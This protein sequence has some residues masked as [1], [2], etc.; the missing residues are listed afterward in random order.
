MII[1]RDIELRRG[2]KLLLQDAQ[3][4]IQPGQN[5]A[6]IG[7]NGSG[8]SSLFALLLGELGADT[9]EI[10]G[11]NN[12]RLSHMAQEVH[13][14]A[15]PA[16]EY[17][18]RGDE[19][20][21]RLMDRLAA[22]EEQGDY[23]LTAPIHTEL[24]S[25]DGYSAARKAEV[26]LQGLGFGE[27]AANRPVSDF[28]GGWR[29]RLN[30]ARALMTPSDMLLLDEPTNHLDLDATLWLQQWLQQYPG[31]LLMIS[32]DRDFI[33]GT[34]E[35]I[36]HIERQQLGS[37][38]GN[39]SQ[40][41]AQ[42]AERLANQQATFEKQQRRISEIDDFVRRFRYKATKAKQAQSR[43]KELE[44]MQTVAPAHID[45]PFDFSFLPPEK[46]SDPLL[47]LDKAALGYADQAILNGVDMQLRPG[48]RYGLL[49]R[50]GAGK[51]T[52]LKSLVGQ[53]PLVG[54][55]ISAGEHC[56]IGYFDQ[57]QLEALDM[58]ASPLLH[59][60]RLSPEAR[61]QEV[62]NFLG[63]FDFRGDA[64]S[65]PVAPFS[66]GEKARLALA[67]VVWQK[68]NLLVLDEPTNHLDLEMRHAMEVALQAFEGALILVSHDRHMLRNTVE[69]LLLVHDGQ[70]EEYKQDL[71]G[72][73]KW[74]LSSFRAD[75]PAEQASEAGDSSRKEK[76]QQAA[77]QRERI[78]PLKKQ[79]DKTEAEM[80]KIENS[81]AA[82]QERL[83]DADIYSEARKNEL[84][85]LLKQEGEFKSRAD[86][87]EETWLELQEE[88]E[89]V[90]A[91]AVD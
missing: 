50:N 86:A 5:L 11:M 57:Q 84:A 18:W 13:A 6:L 87:L 55:Q 63:G 60:Q 51:S 54:G 89:Q 45:S 24:E 38:K 47:R 68:P 10:E 30:L 64:A 43:L 59:I 14:T 72:Y 77:A 15:L 62:L 1:L 4:T 41:E 71:E 82:L 91:L 31:T 61:E 26:L 17:V 85:E 7:A 32:H 66:G 44:R 78:R 70:V 73:E 90:Q 37:Y 48:S 53:L 49:G 12:L 80:T 33:D 88:I 16:G 75:K 34:C 56:N 21:S 65:S 46:S 76:R 29:I 42:R 39:Y 69:E 35:R 36:L 28:S 83:G 81:L 20:L 22:L 2:A 8:K 67:M 23:E 9:G 52:L 3:L 74:I 19:Q 58:E 40:F 79:L 27:N 25:I